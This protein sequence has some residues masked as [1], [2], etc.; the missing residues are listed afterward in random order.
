M[1]LAQPEFEHAADDEVVSARLLTPR[2]ERRRVYV[3]L[4]VTLAVLSATVFTIYLVVPKRVGAMREAALAEH[5]EPGTFDL[6]KPS[7]TELEA[8]S[9]GL[10]GAGVPWPRLEGQ[11]LGA[12]GLKVLHRRVAAVR[13]LID[14]ME[15]TLIASRAVDAPPRTRRTQR[16]GIFCVSYRRG[17]WTLVAAGPADGA[18]AWLHSLG[19]PGGKEQAPK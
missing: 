6:V 17:H 12:R 14:D 10:V 19:A 11:I 16:D 4:F 7:Q 13:Y 3:S 5:A 1:K 18:P 2:P 15:V 9:V 8:W